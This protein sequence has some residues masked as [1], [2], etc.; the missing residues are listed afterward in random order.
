MYKNQEALIRH[1]MREF[2]RRRRS[3]RRIAISAS[4]TIPGITA[5]VRLSVRHGGRGPWLDEIAL[6][7]FR[8]SP[9]LPDWVVSMAGRIADAMGDIVERANG[10]FCSNPRSVGSAQ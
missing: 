9:Y 2:E 10:M 6:V 4:A 1:R 3:P 5:T 7:L 8:L